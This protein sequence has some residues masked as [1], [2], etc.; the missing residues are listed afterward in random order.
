MQFLQTMIEIKWPFLLIEVVFLFGGI[1]LLISGIKTRKKKQI[2]SCSQH[3]CWICNNTSTVVGFILDFNNWIQFLR[4]KN[5]KRI[6]FFFLLS[7]IHD[8][9]I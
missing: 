5:L 4:K 1:A 2:D 6:R 3:S 9:V 8:F 7:I